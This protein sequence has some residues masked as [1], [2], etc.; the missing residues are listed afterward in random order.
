MLQRN[1]NGDGRVLHIRKDRRPVDDGETSR[2]QIVGRFL[3]PNVNL[4]VRS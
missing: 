1:R 4:T 3:I 2:Q